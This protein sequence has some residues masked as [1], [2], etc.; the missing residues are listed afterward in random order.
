MVN[1]GSI[2]WCEFSDP[3]N[4]GTPQRRPQAAQRDAEEGDGNGQMYNESLAEL[5]LGNRA[6]NA[7]EGKG[8]LTVRDLLM[9]T[10]DELLAISQLGEK[11]LEDIFAK[12]RERYGLVR[13]KRSS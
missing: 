1:Y 8:I 13:R 11:T 9:C 12:L 7:L 3:D 2:N 10:R 6:I 4:K 5:G